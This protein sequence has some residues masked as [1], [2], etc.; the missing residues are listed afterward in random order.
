MEAALGNQHHPAFITERAGPAA[1]RVAR[2]AFLLH[3]PPSAAALSSSNVHW[4]GKTWPP[5]PC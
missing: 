3:R 2:A 1:D 5:V 4:V